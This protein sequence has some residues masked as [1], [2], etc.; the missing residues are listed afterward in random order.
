MAAPGG[1]AAGEPVFEQVLP[2]KVT[3]SL[4]V[5]GDKVLRGI[6]GG[7]L[8][9]TDRNDL[10]QTLRMTSG[11]ELSGNNV[12]DLNWSGQNIW[13]ACL[14]GG[15][16]RITDLDGNPSF[17]Q[18]SNNLGS[19]DV[20]AVAGTMFGETERVFYGMWGGGVGQINSGLSGNIYTAEEDGLISNNVNTLQMYLGDLYVGTPVGISRFAN[21][22]FSDQNTGLTN[23]EILDLALDPDGNLL[24]AGNGGVYLWDPN[25]ET[26][27]VFGD[28]GDPVIDLASSADGVFALGQRPQGAGVLNLYDGSTWETVGL[29]SIKCSAIDADGEIWTSGPI[30][31]GTS[32]GRITQN[33]LGRKLLGGDYETV[34]DISGQVRSS[35]GVGFGA[36]GT[37]W[38][39]DFDGSHATGY[40]QED[41]TFLEIYETPHAEND[42]LNIFP[43]RGNILSMIGAPDGR[44]YI[45]QWALGGVIQFN[46]ATTGK[47][48]LIDPSNSGLRG[49]F[50][51]NMVAHPDNA[52]IITH[53]A[54]DL[55]RVEILVNPNEW[56]SSGSW[57]LPPMTEGLS[58]GPVWDALVEKR[59]IIWFAVQGLGLLRWDV[60]GPNAGPNDPLT[61]FDESDDVW[62]DPVGFFN[63]TQLD[64][65]QAR[66]LAVGRDGTIWAG[67]N[68]LVQFSYKL[69][70][71]TSL[72]TT[73]IQSHDEKSPT[74]EE[75]L[76]NNDV[77]DIAVDN[78]GDVWVA[79]QT[80]LNRV[81]PRGEE[82]DIRAWIDLGNYLG[83]PDYQL[84]YSPNVIAPLPG[85]TYA[86]I[87]ASLDGKRMIVSAD[88]GTTL[89]TVGSGPGSSEGSDPLA[90]VFCYPNP[91]TP[92]TNGE[93]LKLGGLPTETVV[94]SVYNLEGQL[95]YFDNLV[96]EQTGFWD[97]TNSSG[98]KVA[99]GMYFMTIATGG[100]TTTRTLAVVN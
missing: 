36:D 72:E 55:Q 31:Y 50:I 82:A 100:M 90:S 96:A 61:W 52:L 51:L 63:D 66:G 4:M 35:E 64:P 23:L 45:S 14:G 8:L 74:V 81:S 80:G 16:T 60:N 26:W 17:R 6:E 37:A 48:D 28:L 92:G 93:K 86:H 97:G 91:W 5:H 77:K 78:N 29:P 62:Y 76:V 1:T 18:Y 65:R 30:D 68:G 3:T 99:T 13:V 19:L 67:G 34:V 32:S 42:T 11:Q 71:G 12:S 56:G 40:H 20:T 57:Y 79:T 73:L 21:N 41:N 87:V 27:S 33:Y 98:K 38:M 43:Q 24:A 39:G 49:K 89:I 58:V 54:P 44:V 59:D 2:A 88:Q 9:I 75:G 22:I 7:G 25:S 69:T 70:G 84:V 53:D 46:A 15:L 47:T 94:V 10:E 83:N 85:T 95:V